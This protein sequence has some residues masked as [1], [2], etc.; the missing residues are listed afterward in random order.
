LR[1]AEISLR[2]AKCGM[3]IESMNKSAFRIPHSAI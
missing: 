2:I 3:W 1:S